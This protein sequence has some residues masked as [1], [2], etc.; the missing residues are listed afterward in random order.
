MS[1]RVPACSLGLQNPTW[2]TRLASGVFRPQ[3]PTNS[4]THRSSRNPPY[5]SLGTSDSADQRSGLLRHYAYLAWWSLKPTRVGSSATSCPALDGDY[6]P[7]P[8]RWVLTPVVQHDWVV[9]LRSEA[10]GTDRK[11]TLRPALSSE[12]GGGR[13]TKFRGIIPF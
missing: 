6:L 13:P 3:P 9:L 5:D 2:A 11:Q 10:R 4:F 12:W 7:V 1:S 8:S